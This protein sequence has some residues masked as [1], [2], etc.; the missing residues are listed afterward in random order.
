M[1]FAISCG[2]KLCRKTVVALCPGKKR[3]DLFVS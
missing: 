1:A 3:T 2:T